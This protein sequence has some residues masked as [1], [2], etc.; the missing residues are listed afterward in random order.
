MDKLEFRLI[1]QIL[2]T[3]IWAIS[4]VVVLL[5]LL[6]FSISLDMGERF[7]AQCTVIGK[8][9]GFSHTGNRSEVRCVLENGDLVV[10]K[11]NDNR[12]YKVGQV[13]T[14]RVKKRKE[15]END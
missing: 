15:L 13:I 7:E 3:N 12:S 8:G 9:V 5:L 4:F 10:R 11:N 1:A 6:L 14:V 2:K